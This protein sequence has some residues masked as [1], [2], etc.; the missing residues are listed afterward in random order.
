MPAPKYSSRFMLC[1]FKQ[2]N[3]VSVCILQEMSMNFR[4]ALCFNLTINHKQ[5]GGHLKM[6]EFFKP[7]VSKI[8]PTVML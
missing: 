4:L 8:Q 3:T 1:F 7:F 5:D 6:T 2:R